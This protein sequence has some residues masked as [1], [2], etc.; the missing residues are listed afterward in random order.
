MQ[1]GAR[2]T[3]GTEATR[4]TRLNSTL[5]WV[6]K[7][8]YKVLTGDVVQRVRER[9][10][11]TCE[12]FE[13]RIIKGVVSKAHVHILVSVPPEMA[14]SEIMRR[15]KG[16]TASKRFEAFPTLKQKWRHFWARGHFCATVG[17]MTEEMIKEYLE[18]HFEPYLAKDFGVEP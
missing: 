6:T 2:W 13:S 1:P 12:A 14:P 18:H 4:F 11:Q 7:Y 17:E 8:R 15:S 10:R 9:V 16:R 5:V 3:I